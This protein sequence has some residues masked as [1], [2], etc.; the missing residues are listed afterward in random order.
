M[1]RAKS[2]PMFSAVAAAALSAVVAGGGCGVDSADID[3]VPGSESA[4]VEDSVTA[5]E[6]AQL[7]SALSQSAT[8]PASLEGRLFGYVLGDGNY[9]PH[10]SPPQNAVFQAPLQVLARDFVLSACKLGYGGKIVSKYEPAGKQ[11]I[12][13][14]T[15]TAS[16]PLTKGTS[17]YV[18]TIE[19]F[20]W[21]SGGNFK[22]Y[23]ES[24]SLA[25]LRGFMGGLLPVEGTT[26]GLIDDQFP[27][28]DYTTDAQIDSKLRAVVK[29][30]DRLGFRTAQTRRNGSV[31]TS[32]CRTVNINAGQEGCKFNPAYGYT[33]ANY[34]RV[35]GA[36]NCQGL[37]CQ[38]PP[39]CP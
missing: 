29:I 36:T 30:L 20:R 5:E 12:D 16:S 15:F 19:G 27:D 37:S 28:S 10:K 22:T 39:R 23:S 2:F 9:H 1:Y 34:A 32:S 17:K 7:T 14:S 13:C 4:A 21:P 31:C 11:R 18:I 6:E 8:D 38:P 25:S 33:F 3:S 35:P 26:S 24:A